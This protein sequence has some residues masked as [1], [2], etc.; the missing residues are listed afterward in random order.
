MIRWNT[1]K[2]VNMLKKSDRDV[3]VDEPGG[4]YDTSVVIIHPKQSN[5]YENLYI[6]GFI[7]GDDAISDW[8]DVNVEMVEIS[9]GQDSSG[10]L[11]SKDPLLIQAYAD[12]R[13]KLAGMGFNIV[14]SMD[15]Y[16]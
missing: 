11:N 5:E 10:G 3:Y 13:I 2:V 12:A 7:T 14:N 4:D 15:E 8:N 9:D 16:F 1:D 6:R